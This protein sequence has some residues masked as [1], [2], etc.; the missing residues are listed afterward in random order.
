MSPYGLKLRM[1]HWEGVMSRSQRSFKRLGTGHSD[2]RLLTSG[3]LNPLLFSGI[4]R[5]QPLPGQEYMSTWELTWFTPIIAICLGVL[6]A[7][8]LFERAMRNR[9]WKA[10]PIR[11][12]VNGTRGKS[13]VTRLIWAALQEAGIP[14]L[15]KTTGTEPRLLLP[16]GTEKPLRRRGKN[17]IREQLRTMLLARR[18][19]ARAVVLECMAIQP[20]LQWISEHALIRSTL[21]VI[22][23]VRMDHMESM[24][25]RLED[26]AAS[27]A[28]TIP[29]KS[30]LV[31]GDSRF[32]Q[33][34]EQKASEVR[35]SVIAARPLEGEHYVSRHAP[36]WQLENQ[37]TASAVA[38]VLG[39]PDDVALAGFSKALVD[40]GIDHPGKTRRPAGRIHYL[41][42][43]AANDADSF[44][45]V[46]NAF[47]SELNA[48]ENAVGQTRWQHSY[49]LVYNHRGDRADRLLDFARRVFPVLPA[50]SIIITG[51][52]PAFA[53]RIALRRANTGKN[54]EFIC[55]RRL[56]A[57]LS[58]AT[59]GSRMIVFCGN[60]RGLD[61][62]SFVAQE[63]HG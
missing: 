15:A 6:T 46:L 56:A 39:I 35:T 28:N 48:E 32:A 47:E 58:Q 2:F 30:T 40:P 13:T 8:G 18:K 21:G 57:R 1:A 53:L 54:L 22:T 5:A 37:A 10:L 9:A 63:C 59:A 23:N 14:A 25:R 36:S 60:T 52:R 16:D 33:L 41:D 42:A 44:L 34:F 62:H 45:S 43:A 7:F 19:G 17:N 26:I 38:R 27:L 11:I 31:L 24:G 49:L 55:P 12:H 61:L 51:D 20:E 3:F 29:V 4:S 50:E